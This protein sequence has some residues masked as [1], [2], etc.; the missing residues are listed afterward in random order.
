MTTT[1]T[2][3]KLVPHPDNVRSDV[4]DVRMLAKSIKAQGIL[5]PL[6]VRDHPEQDGMF[7]IVAGHRRLAAATEA[8][9]VEVPVNVVDLDDEE[10][11][12]V[13]LVENLQ[14]EDISLVDEARAFFRL[15]EHGWTQKRLAEEVGV[16]ADTV[17][18]RL[19]LASLPDL[20]LEKFDSG[21]IPLS[22]LDGFVEIVNDEAYDDGWAEDQAQTRHN[23]ATLQRQL[24]SKKIVDQIRELERHLRDEGETIVEL[25]HGTYG[26]KLPNNHVYIEA[27]G[28]VYGYGDDRLRIDVDQVRADGNL[29]FH[30]TSQGYGE[31]RVVVARPVCTDRGYYTRKSS[32]I[33]DEARPE[34]WE[35][36]QAKR[37]EERAKREAAKEAEQIRLQRIVEAVKAAKKSELETIA[38]DRAI[39]R[40]TST[41]FG[42]AA[43]VLDVAVHD[44]E[45]RYDSYQTMKAVSALSGPKRLEFLTAA[46]LVE[47]SRGELATN[48]LDTYAPVEDDQ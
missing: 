15:V 25:E 27:E 45:G 16:S 23:A 35:E 4:G 6:L 40:L 19:K 39:D 10:V 8:E 9:L 46:Y 22:D 1:I 12:G 34:G 44:D 28:I 37:A 36:A 21:E 48:L 32:S 42:G 3:D 7:Q 13:M 47:S 31:E 20:W 5:E 29:G 18:S 14:R 30:V 41:G 43:K 2:I 33:P 38:V 26:M 17:R 24:N 11:I